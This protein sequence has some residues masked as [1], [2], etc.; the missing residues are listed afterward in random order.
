MWSDTVRS[1]R[2][3]RKFCSDAVDTSCFSIEMPWL[4]H[5][6]TFRRRCEQVGGGEPVTSINASALAASAVTHHVKSAIAAS[7]EYFKTDTVSTESGAGTRH[8]ADIAQ[9]TCGRTSRNHADKFS[10]AKSV[11]FFG[12][13]WSGRDTRWLT[14]LR[15]FCGA[16]KYR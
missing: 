3:S 14:Q 6:R 7:H 13:R 2:L 12:V 11:M 4:H 15:K 5:V 10:F 1:Q 8:R 9:F 16:C